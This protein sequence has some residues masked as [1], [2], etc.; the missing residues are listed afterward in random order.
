M[1]DDDLFEAEEL[2]RAAEWRLRKVDAEPTDEQSVVAAQLLE[3]LA[4]E[5]RALSGSPLHREYT[6]I[7][8]W[9]GESDGIADY[10]VL[11]NNY[12]RRI[13]IDVWPANGDAYL[14][15]MIEL[16]NQVAN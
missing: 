10:A 12:R 13:G 3:R 7:C 16:A 6:A 5:V 8:N 1:S 11:A 14:R 15:A 4:T 2:E 9:L